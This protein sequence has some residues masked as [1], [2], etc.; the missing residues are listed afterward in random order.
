MIETTKNKFG[1]IQLSDL[2]KFGRKVSFVFAPEKQFF[3]T[4]AMSNPKEVA[5]KPLSGDKK[6]P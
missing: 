2:E 5:A 3:A 4:P 6:V 1:S